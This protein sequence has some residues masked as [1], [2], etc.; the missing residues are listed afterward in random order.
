[1]K[2]P[3]KIRPTS[4]ESTIAFIAVIVT[5]NFLILISPY[6]KDLFDLIGL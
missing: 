5:I 1:M 2:W 6:I 3:G 4:Y